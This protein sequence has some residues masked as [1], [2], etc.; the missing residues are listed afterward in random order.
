M[1]RKK[2][3]AVIAGAAA[4]LA[5][6]GA[7]VA[8]GATDVLA[9]EDQSGAIIDDAAAELGVE[10]DAL[11]GALEKALQN[12]VDEAV[13]AGRLTEEQGEALK[14]RIDSGE[15]PLIFGGYGLHG[16]AP[17]PLGGFGHIVEL[18]GA[19]SY[20]G[21]SET[22]VR[23][24][25]REG[26]SLA[27]IAKAEGKSVDGLVQALLVDAR[28]KLDRAVDEGR[29]TDAQA[30]ELREGLEDRVKALVNHEPGSRMEFRGPFHIERHHGPSFW[31]RG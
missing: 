27:E 10:P 18:E 24:E 19:A 31:P 13:K 15:A 21:L 7:G 14:E 2:K 12:R 20:L 8:L 5:V 22:E 9:P 16:L 1:D 25:L 29:L 11:R 4:A 6:A 28:E 3:I 17:G 23:A 30:D 26:K